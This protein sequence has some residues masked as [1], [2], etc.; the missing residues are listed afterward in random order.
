MRRE[1]VAFVL[2]TVTCVSLSSAEARELSQKPSRDRYIHPPRD[3]HWAAA[4]VA[5]V[6]HR[7]EI[8]VDVAHGWAHE[9][10]KAPAVLGLLAVTAPCVAFGAG[11]ALRLPV[12]D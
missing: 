7:S 6:P 8:R 4:L 12:E 5:H 2:L 10:Q 3:A 11:Q 1:A 9:Q